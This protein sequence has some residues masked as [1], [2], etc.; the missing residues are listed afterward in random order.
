LAQ[1]QKLDPRISALHSDERLR[2]LERWRL[3]AIADVRQ[4][5]ILF[6]A[7]RIIPSTAG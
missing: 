3:R 1:A 4:K 6:V 5:M 7:Q 2:Q